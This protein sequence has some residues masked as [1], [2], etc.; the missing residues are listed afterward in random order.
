MKRVFSGLKLIPA[1]ILALI[2]A[3]AVMPAL[4]A[5]EVVP[6]PAIG[7]GLPAIA[8]VVLVALI[9]FLLKRIKI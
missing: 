9:A 3:L 5:V 2:P 7:L 6:A 1:L 8:A 4:A